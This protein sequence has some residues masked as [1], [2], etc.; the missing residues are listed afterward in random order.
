M[1]R[2]Q[3]MAAFYR[4]L[5]LIAVALLV[6]VPLVAV[7]L[8]GFKTMGDLRTRPFGLPS[9][10]VWSNYGGILA[11]AR[12]WRS[13]MNSAILSLSTVVLTLLTASMAAFAFAQIKFFGRRYLFSYFLLGLLF[14]AATAIL[15]LFIR[16]RDFGLL[17]TPWGVV[18]PQSAFGLG[19]AVLLLWSFFRQLPPELWGAAVID[20]C[21]HGRFL[22]HVVLPLSRPILATVS[23]FSL[24]HAWN[25]YL[26]PLTLL[27]TPAEYPWTLTVMD[28]A[29]EYT[30]D[31]QLVLA[32]I[33][34]TLI[35][36]VLFFLLAQ[37]QIVAGL[38]SGAVKG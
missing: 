2:G 8:G 21:G 33:T 15:P 13:L 28:Y 24:V 18:L 20:G 22:W 7:A 4:Y 11:G 1:V 35:P 9:Q 27:N 3:R 10:W 23:V 38:T 34:L 31:W 5:V 17:D 32:F 19:M 37:K 26:L 29:N 25:S 16:I 36:A 6:L 14:P 30:T 12:F